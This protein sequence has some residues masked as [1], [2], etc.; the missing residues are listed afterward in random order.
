MEETF[1]R[2]KN[3][4]LA[5]YWESSTKAFIENLPNYEVRVEV[6]P[7]ILTW[8]KFSGR[9]VKTIEVEK[10]TKDDWVPVKLSFD[11]EDEAKGYILGF[12]DQIKVIEPKELHDKILEMAESAVAFYKR[13]K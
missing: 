10:R 5:Q 1:E 7:S 13:D 4:N 11:T 3:F 2:P 9:S 6:L 12:A 8:L